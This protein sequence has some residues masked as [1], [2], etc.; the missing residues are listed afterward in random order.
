MLCLN[1]V[2]LYA[3]SRSLHNKG[4]TKRTNGKK[5]KVKNTIYY[6][7][8]INKLLKQ[9]NVYSKN[10]IAE[11]AYTE[12]CKIQ[13]IAQLDRNI[14]NYHDDSECINKQIILTQMN[15]NVS[16]NTQNHTNQQNK[17]EQLTDMTEMSQQTNVSSEHTFGYKQNDY[18]HESFIGPNRKP[19]LDTLLEVANIIKDTGMPN[20]RMARIPIISKLN[21]TKWREYLKDYKDQ[22][23]LD[24]IEFSFPISL[25]DRSKLGNKLIK[26][27]MSA[28]SFP[29]EVKK[30]FETE[31]GKLSL[32]GP[33]DTIENTEI[34]C[35][36]LMTRPK[37]NNKRRLILNLSHP[38]RE[39]SK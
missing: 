3:C 7:Q 31:L 19:D 18:K 13:K 22:A 12:T 2:K 20:H 16:H 32:I 21:V 14:S 26:N 6:E 10:D 34:H 23:L 29:T 28:L 33:I 35:S 15:E 11:T 39:F 24:H 17:H 8:L 1:H 37:D 9:N 4:Q 36:P 30:Y 27:H 5:Q 38:E 25:S